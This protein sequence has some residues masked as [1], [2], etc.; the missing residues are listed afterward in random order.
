MEDANDFQG[1]SDVKLDY[2]LFKLV[3]YEYSDLSNNI[4]L[5]IF[6]IQILNKLLIQAYTTVCGPHVNALVAIENFQN[7]KLLYSIK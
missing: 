6:K 1:I 2:I 5:T 7:N 4:I 3:S